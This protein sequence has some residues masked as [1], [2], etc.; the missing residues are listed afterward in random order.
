M[1]SDKEGTVEAEVVVDVVME[2]EGL[3]VEGEEESSSIS[4]GGVDVEDM[5]GI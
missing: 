4:L 5:V 2:D 1:S 3:E